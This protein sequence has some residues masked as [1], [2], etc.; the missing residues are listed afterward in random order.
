MQKK[1]TKYNKCLQDRFKVPSE[2]IKHSGNKNHD[3]T[4]AHSVVQQH[5]SAQTTSSNSQLNNH[6][7]IK[8]HSVSIKS[9][10]IAPS[11]IDMQSDVIESLQNMLIT[12][13]VLLQQVSF[14]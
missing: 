7:I 2:I 14:L 3:S 13:N 5:A 9:S 4:S 11:G 1:G 10:I 8:I 6:S 12:N